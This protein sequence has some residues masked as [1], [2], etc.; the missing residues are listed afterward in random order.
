MN[1]NQQI[2]I[3]GTGGTISSRYDPFQGRSVASQEVEK[4][5]ALLPGKRDCLGS[6]SGSS[7]ASIY[8]FSSMPLSTAEA[9]CY[10]GL[11]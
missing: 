10:V 5:V 9:I 1:V 8:P 4:I 3:V 2:V 7:Q 6:N 11:G